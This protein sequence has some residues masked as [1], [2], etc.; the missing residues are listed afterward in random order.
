[1]TLVK[2]FLIVGSIS[3]AL[4]FGLLWFFR[5]DFLGIVL[6]M[7][8]GD[9]K[10]QYES[11]SPEINL[12]QK[13]ALIEADRLRLSSI[14]FF[15]SSVRGQSDAS[16]FLN[17]LISWAE[18][19]GLLAL[20]PETKS[21]FAN[22]KTS[23]SDIK[24]D[25][26]QA[27]L[28]FSWFSSLARF[29]VWS[30]D[31]GG[32]FFD[33]G[34]DYNVLNLPFPD[35]GELRTWSKLRLLKGRDDKALEPAFKEVRQLAKLMMSQESLLSTMSAISLLKA[36]TQFYASLSEE[37]RRTLN[38][39]VI[40]A[41]DLAAARRY[42]WAQLSFLDL[43]LSDSSFQKHASMEP[44][45]CTRVYEALAAAHELRPLAQRY[46]AASYERLDQLEKATAD[47]CRPSAIRR[48]W[49]HPQGS[50]LLNDKQDLLE[51][52]SLADDGATPK[53]FWRPRITLREVEKHP[54][55][56]GPIT[57]LMLSLT[58]NTSLRLY[59]D[60]AKPGD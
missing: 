24:V 60:G 31:Q 33:Q 5:Y 14:D 50:G 48:M 22:S 55:L 10:T 26:K 57:Y 25:W 49:T 20:A 7:S 8:L 9:L 21:L 29:D 46:L 44:G 43:R 11:R 59:D 34:Q 56:A 38:W 45:L 36:E 37:E 19:P 3:L 58:E 18:K 47:K 53:S 12:E 42:Y 4:I 28:D 2:K 54:S 35:Y 15:H 13:A 41:E 52:M 1:M 40:S 23:F 16:T 39:S 17:P 30:F 51:A 27:N 32:P 6:T